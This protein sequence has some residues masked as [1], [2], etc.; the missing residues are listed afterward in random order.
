MGQ[1]KNLVVSGSCRV[2][3]QIKGHTETMNIF[4][5]SCSV[6]CSQIR[7]PESP[8][9]W[10]A[11]I[12][13]TLN[14]QEPEKWPRTGANREI[15]KVVSTVETFINWLGVLVDGS[16]EKA[17][18]WRNLTTNWFNPNIL[19]CS[20]KQSTIQGNLVGPIRHPVSET[21]WADTSRPPE[22]EMWNIRFYGRGSRDS[23]VPQSKLLENP[24]GMLTTYRLPYFIDCKWRLCP[25][26]WSFVWY[27][28]SI[29]WSR[30]KQGLET[31]WI[32]CMN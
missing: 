17:K 13:E 20:I 27:D 14:D 5:F 30:V 1:I 25:L 29:I 26:D 23:T 2:G 32:S 12:P 22:I 8:G 6:E 9:Q 4:Y 21:F 7:L 11:Q 15:G 31:W 28:L 19:G 24:E 18:W 3:F 10:E 16:Q